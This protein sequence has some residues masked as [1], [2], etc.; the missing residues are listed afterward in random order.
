MLIHFEAINKKVCRFLVCMLSQRFLLKNT[1]FINKFACQSHG[2]S[3][4]ALKYSINN[5]KIK[6]LKNFVEIHSRL[7]KWKCK[8]LY[9]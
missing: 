4:N 7:I 1:N 5:I 9:I 2:S 8:F 6:T 3:F